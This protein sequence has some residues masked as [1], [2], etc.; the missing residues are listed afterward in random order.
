MKY[1]FF[2]SYRSVGFK[3]NIEYTKKGITSA[4]EC[5]DAAVNSLAAL[6]EASSEI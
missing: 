1:F 6:I 4:I 3:G 5:A 2:W